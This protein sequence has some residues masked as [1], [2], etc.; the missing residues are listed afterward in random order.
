MPS[1]PSRRRI[2]G[3]R[4]C[5]AI[6]ASVREL[7]AEVPFAELSVAAIT[8]R[9]GMTRSG[10]YFY[11]DSKYAVLAA[12][13]AE[14]MAELEE[15]THDFAP[16]GPGETPLAF[17]KRTVAAA[18][19]VYA[20]DDPAMRAC[21]VAQNTDDQIRGMM[22]DFVDTV[23]GKIVRL[24]EQDLSARPISPD[25]GALVR[26]LAA[27]TALTVGGD[28]NFVGRSDDRGLA[29]EVIERLW[30]SALWGGAGES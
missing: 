29:V 17:A 26:T 7:L 2:R 27:A 20:S 16:I 22:N 25:I 4:R 1:A 6:V 15:L 12:I 14:R 21:L 10:F 3:D 11:F 19:A 23:V 28:R 30:A 8:K 24:V 9:A 18:A 13:L 5:D